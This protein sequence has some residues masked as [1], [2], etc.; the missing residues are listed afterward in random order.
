MLQ[1]PKLANRRSAYIPIW[2]ALDGILA[3]FP[4]VYWLFAGPTPLIFGLP[5]SIVYF[6]ALVVFIAA[7]IVA[8]YRDDEKR[9]AF[10]VHK[11]PFG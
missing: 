6:V 5:S 11:E 9:G 1:T 8:A 3:L 7:S 2:F 10:E 4:P